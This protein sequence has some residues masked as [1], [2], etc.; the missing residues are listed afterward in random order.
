MEPD[1]K[2]LWE[3]LYDILRDAARATGPAHLDSMAR[4]AFDAVADQMLEMKLAE[5]VKIWSA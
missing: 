3:D 5:S 4:I 2:E 1:Y